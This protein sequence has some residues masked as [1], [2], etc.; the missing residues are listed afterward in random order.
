MNDT[1]WRDARV[2]VTGARGFIATHLCR[3]LAESGAIVYGVSSRNV[4]EG[5]SAI[6]WLRADVKD[7]ATSRR[8]LAQTAPDV[9]FHL[10]GQVT[11]AQDVS[12]VETTFAVN[13]A[14]TVHLLTAAAEKDRCRVVLA[15][16]M[17]EPDREEVGSELCS[18]Y[19]VSKWACSGY[20]RMFRSLYGLPV[21]I[22]RLMMVYGP[23]QWDVTKL[24]PYVTTS[25]LAG[26]PPALGS[27]TREMDWVFVEDVVEG[28]MTIARSSALDG[29]S[30][31]LGTGILT[32]NRSIVEQ[33][34]ALVGGDV[35]V[36]FGA[37]ADRPFERPRVA[38]VQETQQLTGWVAK[39]SLA[40][41]LSRT[42]AWY[43]E[44][45]CSPKPA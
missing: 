43:R 2:L 36:R 32:S 24:L 9:V 41:G 30:I 18:P 34:A 35:S 5:A 6:T 10:A 38:R 15:G 13:L 28:F 33:V 26:S 21:V 12:N 1:D 22:A 25:L 4:G 14:S 20:A 27:G 3:Q 8:L 39:T 23:G 42:V 11:G 16:S 37:L 31:D 45:W 19:A 44:E 40:E 7:A 29:R 17:Q